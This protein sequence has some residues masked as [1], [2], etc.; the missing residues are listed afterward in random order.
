MNI[1]VIFLPAV[2]AGGVAP[3]WDPPMLLLGKLVAIAAL[4]ALNAF[5]VACEFSIVKTR[6]ALAN[7]QLK[8]L[9]TSNFANRTSLVAVRSGTQFR[10]NTAS[11][12]GVRRSWT[13][14]L[15]AHPSR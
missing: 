8:F 11:C 4:V 6:L 15:G 3:H 13:I 7:G 12:S 10:P 9:L 2:I 14:R 5:F 1:P